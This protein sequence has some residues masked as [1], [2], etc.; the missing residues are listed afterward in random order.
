MSENSYRYRYSSVENAALYI[1]P[2]PQRRTV[3]NEM[4]KTIQTKA[5]QKTSISL[6][7]LFQ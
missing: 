4:G 3:E 5:D 2:C 1:V 7:G 6:V